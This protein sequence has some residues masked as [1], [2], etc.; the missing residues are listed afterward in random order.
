M[1]TEN[2]KLT[3]E[4]LGRGDIG[5]LVP[6]P[7]LLPLSAHP[8]LLVISRERG[9]CDIEVWELVVETA[10]CKIGSRL[11]CTMCGRQP[12]LC[13]TCEWKLTFKIV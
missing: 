8:H 4:G 9:E 2:S 10:G 12:I 5:K 7:W 13:N 6:P 11:C 1:Q 3:R